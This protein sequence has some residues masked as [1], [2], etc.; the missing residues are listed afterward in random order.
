MN[1]HPQSDDGVVVH[2]VMGQRM[3]HDLLGVRS[4]FLDGHR[5]PSPVRSMVRASWER[6]LAHRVGPERLEVPYLERRDTDTPLVRA[7]T[8]VLDVLNEQLAGEPVSTMLTDENGV[9]LLRHASDGGLISRLDRAEL[10]S[11]H[12]FSEEAVGTNGIGTALAC[13]R[14]VTIDGAEHFVAELDRFRC[15]A[16]PIRHPVRKGI[17]GAFNVTTDTRRAADRTA[18]ALA[19]ST[20]AHIERELNLLC[21]GRERILFE[22]Y[23]SACRTNRR[24]AVLAVDSEVLLM[25]DRLRTTLVGTD[26]A[27]LIDRIE[28]TDGVLRD[29]TLTL[30]SGLVVELRAVP[31][32]DSG[33][34]VAVRLMGR[35]AAR[36]DTGPAR[37]VP[38]LIGSD[39]MWLT[40]VAAVGEAH[41]RRAGICVVGEAGTG[42][43]HLL[44]ALH[45]SRGR[46]PCVL[47]E[48]PVEQSRRAED[49]LLD[50]M[51][52]GLRRPDELV[53]LRNAQWWSSRARAQI[54]NLLR[55]RRA[56]DTARVALTVLP[57]ASDTADELVAAFPV[58]VQV[59]PLR[60]RHDDVLALSRYF[61][62]RY[63]PQRD[64]TL[65]PSAEHA[66]Q[67]FGWPGGVAQ[68]ERVIQRIS[69]SAPAGEVA[70]VDLP[71]ELH[72]ST[73]AVLTPL[74]ELERDAIV[75]GLVGYGRN[76]ARTARG[77]G[78]SRATMYRRMRHYG[79]E[80][81]RL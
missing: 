30:P 27:A 22:R 38:G 40:A 13:A 31:G 33:Q 64:L 66:L 50:T 65:A 70:A 4:R 68:L 44:T 42:K 3:K 56:T 21:S 55:D 5:G 47:V 78:I 49:D 77:L 8:A 36:T 74:Q 51:R 12:V 18:L 14:P 35:T 23:L 20:V 45:H 73:R 76:V 62:R 9:I 29:R 60:H 39:P 43:A 16:V 25:N 58:Q 11:G 59:P 52:R 46:G 54:V 32:P 71:P 69:R 10:S 19:G 61:L 28:E 81:T 24:T 17:I 1:C 15:T 80:P 53:V 75:R 2:G 26:Q 34:V 57:S 41:A 72:A 63:R 6:S 7:A 48:P 37:S 79:I 67:R